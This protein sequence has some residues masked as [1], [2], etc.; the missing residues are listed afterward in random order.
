MSLFSDN[1]TF[2]YDNLYDNAIKNSRKTNKVDIKKPFI[3]YNENIRAYNSYTSPDEK[4]LYMN[5]YYEDEEGTNYNRSTIEE[6]EM[7][8]QAYSLQKEITIGDM[9]NI[10]EIN[11]MGKYKFFSINAI[12]FNRA[13]NNISDNNLKK[14]QTVIAYHLL[15]Q[16]NETILNKKKSSDKHIFTFFNIDKIINIDKNTFAI[17]ISRKNK[18][19]NFTI[20]CNYTLINN[21]DDDKN[22]E[23]KYNYLKLVGINSDYYFNSFKKDKL[24]NSASL[25]IDNI[26][27][28][29]DYD[30]QFNKLNKKISTN[31]ALF[32]KDPKYHLQYS[33]NVMLYPDNGCFI[34]NKKNRI[35]ELEEQNPIRCKSYW[36]EYNYNGVWDKKCNDNEDCPFYDKERNLGGC[37]KGSGICEM[38]IGV[39]R[40]GYRQYLKDTK[41]KCNNCPISNPYC[42]YENNNYNIKDLKF[43]N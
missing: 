5:N 37:Y 40:I 19:Y 22:N 16:I 24:T 36:D 2:S 3:S 26:K 18:I 20:E 13:V 1:K 27:K 9:K 14:V 28:T 21:N 25:V 30:K 6:N 29:L 11:I 8:N 38:P 10:L 33:E 17:K 7:I 42:C 43:L 12:S 4:L 35:E 15:F 31:V 41:P 23:V 34:L 32:G 39:V